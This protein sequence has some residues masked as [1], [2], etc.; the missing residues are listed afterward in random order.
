MHET[1]QL[2]GD[3]AAGEITLARLQA[4]VAVARTRSFG[5]AAS[6][7]GISQSGVSRSV[8][9]VERALGVALFERSTRR[10]TLT[11]AGREFVDR[12]EIALTDVHTAITAVRPG[13]AAG[14]SRQVRIACLTSVAPTILAPA[15]GRLAS[16]GPPRVGVA[17]VF[18]DDVELHVRTA[19][20]DLG[21]ADVGNLPPDLRYRPLWSEEAVVCMPAD[22]RLAGRSRLSIADLSGEQ[23]IGF[24]RDT[25]LRILVDRAL[26][27]AGQLR[28]SRYIVQHYTT[29]VALVAAGC[30]V[31]VAPACA[32]LARPPDLHV[33]PLHEPDVRRL[34]G[35]IW[36]PGAPLP[37]DLERILDALRAEA[38]GRPHLRLE[39]HPQESPA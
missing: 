23:L 14:G 19:R 33:V 31:F 36:R 6:A 24:P 11:G 7:L 32:T 3:V 15:L 5:A 21:I 2:A 8:A 9:A 25:R 27:E 16:E 35:A 26:A 13:S 12:A 1:H 18:Q 4:V 22:H 20:A 29:A 37:P 28:T 34:V 38:G 17:E 39:G 30:G 10:V